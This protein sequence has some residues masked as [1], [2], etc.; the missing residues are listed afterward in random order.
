MRYTRRDSAT[1]VTRPLGAGHAPSG[2]GRNC[3]ASTAACNFLHDQPV[4]LIGA[5]IKSSSFT[6]C[7]SSIVHRFDYIFRSD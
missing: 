7:A 4:D 3:A 1:T 5:H 6:I 2:S